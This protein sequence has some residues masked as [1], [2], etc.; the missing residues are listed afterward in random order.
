MIIILLVGLSALSGCAFGGKNFF[1]GLGSREVEY[2]PDGTV[3]KEK[4]ESKTPMEDVV[5]ITAGVKN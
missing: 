5:N 3:K 2:Y 4:M 1:F